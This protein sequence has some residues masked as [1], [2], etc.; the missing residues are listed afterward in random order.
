MEGHVGI[1][2]HASYS[3]STPTREAGDP[4]TGSPAVPKDH[5]GQHVPPTR[6][7]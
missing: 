7:P 2:A 1:I 4:S 6:D 5:A 3:T